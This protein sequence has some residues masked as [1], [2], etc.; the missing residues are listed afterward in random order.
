MLLSNS[1][2]QL[3]LIYGLLSL[4]VLVTGHLGIRFL[5]RL[6]RWVITGVV[7]GIIWMPAS[8]SL[9]TLDQ[10]E[11][12]TGLAPAVVVTAVAVLQ[13]KGVSF[14]ALLLVVGAALGALLGFGVWRLLRRPLAPKASAAERPEASSHERQEPVIG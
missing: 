10:A 6:P 3:W 2:P 1:L 7:A 13:G 11:A 9:T 14:A 12:H 4:V 5:P 8:Y